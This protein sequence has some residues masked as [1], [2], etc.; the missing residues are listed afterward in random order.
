MPSIAVSAS[1]LG[2]STL[3]AAAA[4][5]KYRVRGL[6]LSAGG[7][8]N[9]TWKS[10]GNALTGAMPMATGTPHVLPL[11][12]SNSDPLFWFETSPG[13]AL[14]LNLSAAVQVGGV[15]DYDSM[16]V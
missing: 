12:G 10:A 4:N 15:L 14:I 8:V 9:V 13:E 7:A 5:T 3:L 11:G 1:A 16:K 6:A 2:D